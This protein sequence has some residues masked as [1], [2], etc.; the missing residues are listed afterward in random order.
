MQEFHSS[1][2][3]Q[4]DR[5]RFER[6]RY[7]LRRSNN[8]NSLLQINRMNNIIKVDCKLGQYIPQPRCRHRGES[9]RVLPPQRPAQLPL[10][11]GKYKEL[12]K[13]AN[14]I[15]TLI[16]HNTCRTKNGQEVR[17]DGDRLNGGRENTFINWK[18]NRGR[19]WFTR[20]GCSCCDNSSRSRDAPLSP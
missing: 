11:I 5:A 19:A 20:D 13:N 15:T 2:K 16:N 10:M 14:I 7:E 4:N 6:R 18:I 3:D 9:R 17:E 8:L 1:F 12:S